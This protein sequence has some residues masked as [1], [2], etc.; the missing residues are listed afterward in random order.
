MQLKIKLFLILLNFVQKLKGNAKFNRPVSNL[1][2]KRAQ[3]EELVENSFGRILVF[4]NLNIF[5]PQTENDRKEIVCNAYISSEKREQHIQPMYKEF[6]KLRLPSTLQSTTIATAKPNELIN[7]LNENINGQEIPNSLMLLI[8]NTGSGKTTFIRYFK[9]LI[10]NT[11]YPD[12]ACYYEW[13]FL[14]MN[15]APVSEKE[16]YEWIRDKIIE[17]FKKSYTEI[18]NGKRDFLERLF[19]KEIKNFENGKG[20]FLKDDKDTYNKEM[21]KLIS[22]NLDDKEKYIK[23]LI[24]YL[25]SYHSKVPIIVLDNCDKRTKDEQLLMFQVAQWIKDNYKF[26][27]LLPMRDST[28]DLYKKQPPLDTVVKDLVFRIDPADL[29]KVLQARL[30]Y[31]TRKNEAR[32]EEYCF[33][34][35][36]RVQMRKYEQVEYFKCILMAIRNNSWA[37]SIFYHLSNGNIREAIQLFED[38]CKSGH[39]KAEDIFKI[40][41]ADD[42]YII[43]SEKIINPLLRKNRKY[44]SEE[45]SNFANLFYANP[46]D[47]LPDP[48]VRIDILLWL[49]N[50]MNIEGPNKIPGYHK[51]SSLMGDLQI[52]GH[53]ESIIFREIKSLVE[54]NLFFLNLKLMK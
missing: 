26:L 20:Q 22:E 16:I 50:Y 15:N 25:I 49:K 5:N 41:N 12:L 6:K 45:K 21:Y 3:D 4:D 9:E 35:G 44:F 8:G 10:L 1:G 23:S 47:D 54:K 32:G 42:N 48:F 28:F 30:D 29:L 11:Q 24:E 40:R 37:M 39:I 2:G 33:E 36:I 27:V 18:E 43:S 34:N 46:D 38:F 51:V 13:I 7:K 17:S 53:S 14:D 19:K 52:V 31:I